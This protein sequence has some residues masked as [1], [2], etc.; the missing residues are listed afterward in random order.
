M[1]RELLKES[2]RE[3]ICQIADKFPEFSVYELENGEL[4]VE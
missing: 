3:L 2:D 4:E 1:D